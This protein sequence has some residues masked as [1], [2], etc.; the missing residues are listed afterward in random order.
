MLANLLQAKYGEGVSISHF[1]RML[2]ELD[3]MPPQHISL[4]DIQQDHLE[5][6]QAYLEAKK[7][8]D[9]ERESFRS[10]R[11]VNSIETGLAKA[12]KF[13]QREEQDNEDE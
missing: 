11:S 1:E 6:Y 13:L 2:G 12:N 5:A 7:N 9:A 4:L 3:S 8:R 10:S